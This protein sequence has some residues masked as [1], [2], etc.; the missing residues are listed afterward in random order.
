MVSSGKDLHVTPIID[1]YTATGQYP[2]YEAQCRLERIE[3]RT[4]C[5]RTDFRA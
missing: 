3:L 5:G 4:A 2:G 1:S